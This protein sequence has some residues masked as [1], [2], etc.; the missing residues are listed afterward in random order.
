MTYTVVWKPG[1]ERA[2]TTIWNASTDRQLIADASDRLDADLRRDAHE[3]GE[4]RPNLDVRI[5]FE[6][7]LGIRFRVFDKDR[8]VTV[9]SVWRVAK[10]PRT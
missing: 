5:A 6:L 10:R 2:L 8:L 4:S 9:V 7:P 1:A 3:V